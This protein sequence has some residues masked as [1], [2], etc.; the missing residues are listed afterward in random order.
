[1]KKGKKMKFALMLACM[2]M[3]AMALG[4]CGLLG[5]E[6]SSVESGTLAYELSEDGTQ[7]ALIGI[8]TCK[9][10]EVQVPATYN[11][12]PVTSV[13]YEAFDYYE[14]M[15]S[16]AL[17]DS[18][19]L[20]G[21]NAFY[22]CTNLQSITFGSGLKT[23]DVS[24][25]EGCT[26]LTSVS[27][28]A[29]LESVG[30]QAFMECESLKDVTFTST[31]TTIFEKAFTYCVA[32]ENLDLTGVKEIGD[33]AF[34]GCVA[35]KDLQLKKTAVL[36][37]K[38]FIDCVGLETADLGE[39]LTII[40]DRAFGA[41]LK[42]QSLI[43]PKTLQTLSTA[44]FSGSSKLK[45][46]Y[47]RGTLEECAFKDAFTDIALYVYSEND[48][49]ANRESNYDD[50]FWHMQ[51]GQVVHWNERAG[52][53]CVIVTAQDTGVYSFA[54]KGVV[55]D[56][57]FNNAQSSAVSVSTDTISVSKAHLY[58]NPGMNT[59]T[60]RNENNTLYV[61]T[62]K[63]VKNGVLDFEE[64]GL[65]FVR[66][67]SDAEVKGIVSATASTGNGAKSLKMEGGGSTYIGIDADFVNA[68]FADPYVTA[69]QFKVY[70]KYDLRQKLAW[71]YQNFKMQDGVSVM[72]GNQVTN[73]ISYEDKGDYLLITVPRSTYETWVMRNVYMDTDVMQFLFRFARDL[74]E[75]E[76]P[77]SEG[78]DK[79]TQYKWVSAGTFYIDDIQGVK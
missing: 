9:D 40:G 29:N 76:S 18:V 78:Q 50:L 1:M 42:L 72:V 75:G 47:Y 25:F 38:A 10:A 41:C 77:T 59:L 44:H 57:K 55:T 74:Q 5:N 61:Y 4:A 31:A 32:L 34:Q 37:N 12:L 33:S 36:K 22:Q 16:I 27:F 17:P 49:F 13:R 79:L 58:A 53:S 65:G 7:Y 20:I 3:S 21:E 2:G 69:M 52:S 19:E 28:G 43:V 64:Y 46:I 39:S 30:K 70:T 45:N 51:N 56:V 15:T 26:A 73:G 54:T 67:T 14:K 60:W 63:S 48:P 66:G 71:Y 8:G 62:L 24:A 23:I 11:G 68:L 35:L 6:S